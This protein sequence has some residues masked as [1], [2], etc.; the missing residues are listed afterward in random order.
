MKEARR[1]EAQLQPDVIMDHIAEVVS[2]VDAV[3]ARVE[4][5]A[6]KQGST[7]RT[8]SPTCPL[9][10][11][12]PSPTR[13][14]NHKSMS[15]IENVAEATD[16]EMNDPSLLSELASVS[17]HAQHPSIPSLLAR[18]TAL[19]KEAVAAKQMGDTTRAVAKLR[20]AKALQSEVDEIQAV[21]TGARSSGLGGGGEWAEVKESEAKE[22]EVKERDAKERE[23]SK[24]LE[25]AREREAK[26][27]EEAK[28]LEE[29]R[30]IEAKE[31]DEAKKL[32]EARE[33][34]A[35]EREE[36]K[37]LEEAKE[38]EANEKEAKE[39][40]AKER[41]A[42][43]REMKEREAKERETKE[44]EEAKA[45][46]ADAQ[47]QSAAAEAKRRSERGGGEG[48]D[49][50]G[51]EEQLS[52]AALRARIGSLRAEAIALKKAGDNMGA[53]AKYRDAKGEEK[54]LA[55]LEGSAPS[56]V[57]PAAVAP[58]AIESSRISPPTSTPTSNRT[59][60]GE[61][62][63]VGEVVRQLKAEAVALSKA[64]RKAEAVV[65]MK[66]AKVRRPY[67]RELSLHHLPGPLLFPPQDFPSIVSPHTLPS[68]HLCPRLCPPTYTTTFPPTSSYLLCTLLPA[69]LLAALLSSPSTF[70]LLPS[71]LPSLSI[72]SDQ[73]L[74]DDSKPQYVL[75][76]QMLESGGASPT[77]SPPLSPSPARMKSTEPI[78]TPHQPSIPPSASP[79]ARTPPR[80]L[81]KQED[82]S[83]F[84]S[85]LSASELELTILSAK[86]QCDGECPSFHL[87]CPHLALF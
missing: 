10:L 71:A 87:L 32:E 39:R 63:G 22:T 58:P 76:F 24:K 36:A 54:R 46:R 5:Q 48:G 82:P 67:Q 51:G 34:V 73:P 57:A 53:M 27:R 75:R 84:N 64:G 77:A 11:S 14:M 41:E 31:R 28:K 56:A 68:I 26:E 78:R 25:E 70:L 72:P 1:L 38:R 42:T 17:Q 7:P 20:E 21:M 3:S 50:R 8:R 16:E 4:R 61:Y 9:I 81:P 12:L 66:Q 69:Y 37:K 19:K 59:S 86:L 44:R 29:A 74:P 30:E 79:Q 2:T 15:A 6:S 62:S 35:K 13:Q 45:S 47:D 43:E 85:H 55:Q 80:A 18:V 23:E 40:E 65:K 49:V 52:A 83:F 60:F 33:K